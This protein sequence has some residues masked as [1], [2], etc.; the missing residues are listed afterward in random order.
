MRDQLDPLHGYE[1]GLKPTVH[2]AGIVI[3]AEP[4][5]GTLTIDMDVG[6]SEAADSLTYGYSTEITYHT[7]RDLINQYRDISTTTYADLAIQDIVNEA[8]VYEENSLPVTLNL[9][10]TMLSVKIKNKIID[11]F[12]TILKL[13]DFERDGDLIF[14]RWYV[15]GRLYVYKHLNTKSKATERAGISELRLIDPRYIKKVTRVFKNEKDDEVRRESFFVYYNPEKQARVGVRTQAIRMSIDSITYL[16]CGLYDKNGMVLSHLHKALKPANQLTGIEDAQIIYRIA[17]A[18]ERRVFYV[19]V[20][21]LPKTIAEQYMQNV[22][23]KYKNKM[24]YDVTT[25][26]MVDSRHIKTMLED[27]WL[28]RRDGSRGTEVSNLQGGQSLAEIDDIEYF[29]KKLYESMNVPMSRLVAEAGFNLGKSGEIERD[30]VKFAK[31]IDRLRNRFNHLFLDTLKT[32]CVAK[33]IV[34]V[35]DWE[36]MEQEVDIVYNKDMVFSELKNLEI[37]ENRLNIVQ[38]LDELVGVY[39]SNEYVAKE[40]LKMSDETIALEKKRMA[41]EADEG[42]ELR[43]GDETAGDGIG[44]T[45]DRDGDDPNVDDDEKK[46]SDKTPVDKAADK[47][48]DDDKE[49]DE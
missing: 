37:L 2:K 32:Q 38:Q 13:M 11:E 28:P 39:Y 22:M 18:P 47:E 35:A 46:T 9:D 33:G 6:A 3:P 49:K 44:D 21:Q 1:L 24:T 30:E 25:G 36:D 31:F 8:L 4:E 43:G 42:D 15:D 17:R 14:R 23:K 41:K 16:D 40:I 29:K 19:D 27:I 12:A 7:E 34:T 20:G 45:V 48:S 5:P 26:K 10:R